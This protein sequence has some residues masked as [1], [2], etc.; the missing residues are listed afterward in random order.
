LETKVLTGA[1]L[2]SLNMGISLENMDIKGVSVQQIIRTETLPEGLYDLCIRA[3]DFNSNTQL[4]KDGLGCAMFNITWYDPPVIV[5]PS[6][7]S[8]VMPLTPQFLEHRL[9]PFWPGRHHPLPAYHDGH[10]GQWFGEPK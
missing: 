5:Q 8:Q 9:D 10:D 3:F 6:D 4:S 1:Q 2:Q 7:K